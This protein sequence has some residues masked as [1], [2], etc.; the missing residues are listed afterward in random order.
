MFQ[1]FHELYHMG[2]Q[3]LL[4]LLGALAV[5]YLLFQSILVPYE[6]ER[7]PWSSSD[8][9]NVVMV[10]KVNVPIIEDV[11]MHNYKKSS[12]VSDGV[13][14]HEVDRNDFHILLGKK[15][16]GKN[17]SLELDNVGSKKSFIAVLAKES[18]V[19]FSVK[20]SLETK[21]G[22]STISQLAKSKNIDSREHDGVGF[23]ASQ[24]SIS[25]TN[26]TRLEN[27]PQIKKLSASDKST[28]ADNI[29]VRKMRCN[30]PP[31][32]RMLIQEMN[33]LLE[34]RRTSS[35]AMVLFLA[36]TNFLVATWK[37]YCCGVLIYFNLE[38]Y[39]DCRNQ[40]GN[41]N[42]IW[43]FLQQGQRLSMLLQ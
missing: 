27:S 16:V 21:R 17:R 33:H 37:N 2:N 29:T 43:K 28:A 32:S 5:N 34:R 9:N 24:S 20:P 26:R 13:S 19:D 25:L 30:M 38:F 23:G 7:A 36:I 18:K 12:L 41:P 4:F 3:R 15:D 22:I 39:F 8:F 11:G 31:K 10:E 6:N 1:Y 35:R 14:E 42:L 40:G